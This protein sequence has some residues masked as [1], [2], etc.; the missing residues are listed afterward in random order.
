MRTVR[1]QTRKDTD[2][3]AKPRPRCAPGPGLETGVWRCGG[4]PLVGA[5]RRRA[6]HA[7]SRPAPLPHPHP[8]RPVPDAAGRTPASARQGPRCWSRPPRPARDG[9]RTARR[10]ALQLGSRRR[11]GPYPSLAKTVIFFPIKYFM[12]LR[13]LMRGFLNPRGWDG[14]GGGEETGTLAVASK[15]S[16]PGATWKRAVTCSTGSGS[17]VAADPRNRFHSAHEGQAEPPALLP[18]PK[19]TAG[20]SGEVVGARAAPVVGSVSWDMKARL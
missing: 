12:T 17:S 1:G 13:G 8:P 5:P 2:P 3:E 7:H 16:F 15:P 6:P 20:L 11:W 4:S 19:A 18:R 10:S 14:R 9:A